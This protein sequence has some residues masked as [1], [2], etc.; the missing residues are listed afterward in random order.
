[1]CQMIGGWIN[2]QFF[3]D[4]LEISMQFLFQHTVDEELKLSICVFSQWSI[5]ILL[6]QATHLPKLKVPGNFPGCR[7]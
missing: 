4:I 6:L 7:F 2:P 1:M 3:Q 5:E